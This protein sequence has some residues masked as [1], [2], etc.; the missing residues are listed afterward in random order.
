[1]SSV[2]HRGRFSAWAEAGFGAEL[3]PVEPRGK[4]VRLED[5]PTRVTTAKDLAAW[6]RNGNSVGLRN[7]HFPAIDI[8]VDDD[9]VARDLVLRVA[10]RI[11]G[12]SALRS[13]SGSTRCALLYRL[14]G[15]PFGVAAVRFSRSGEARQEVQVRGTG[16]QLVVDGI[17][18]EGVPYEWPAGEPSAEELAPITQEKRDRFLGELRSELG[19]LGYELEGSSATQA[20]AP[21]RAPRL[22]VV[23]RA[24]RYLAKVPGAISGSGGHAQT[25]LAAEHLVLGFELDQEVALSVLLNDYNPRCS[26]AWTEKD[27]RHKVRE[28]AE[29]GRA[30]RP[31][32]HLEERPAAGAAAPAHPTDRPAPAEPKKQ[33][34]APP[35]IFDLA[36][37]S[38]ATH[39]AIEA[40][41]LDHG[42]Q[43]IPSGWPRLDKAL[44]GGFAVPSLNI[45]GAAPK[46]GK[47]TWAQHV[48]VHHLGQGGAV[49]YVDLENGRRRF[50]RQLICRK[51]ELGS[52][53]V[54]RALENE[55]AG[56]FTTKAEAARWNDAKAWV[57]QRLPLLF[58]SFKPPADWHAC[59]T[60]VRAAAGAR[61]LLVVVDS[62]QKLPGDLAE[63]RSVVDG[64]VR[65]FEQ[66]R[67]ELDAVFLVIS[68]IKRG[69]EGYK[70]GEDAFKESGG[71][72][73]AADLAMT[74]DR[75]RA[76][77][78]E[79]SVSTLRIELARDCDEDP[80]GDVASYVPVRPHYG[81]QE[82]DPEPRKERKSRGRKA[83][84]R[85][86]AET[87]LEQLLQ[88]GPVAV[89]ELEA[90]AS[91]EGI[92]RAT[93]NRAKDSIGAKSCT[94][95]LHSAWRLP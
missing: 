51:A 79:E 4:A 31:G 60:A 85:G 48:A 3:V 57:G 67:H 42:V 27:L 87:L 47:S 30:V 71:I 70:A 17:H 12:A 5:W 52:S 58:A 56:V 9:P 75:P 55:R 15:D 83:T 88:D 73:Y 28:A 11:L 62:L 76:D 33:D 44:G 13:R 81:L 49:L 95:N 69:R 25:L 6:D 93:L 24:R 23:E 1:M 10:E 72:E 86:K 40:H 74:M 61:K 18:P 89:G 29:K 41:T 7:R 54:T 46:S 35:P 59:L 32:Q 45:I 91:A 77:E 16:M 84:A 92:S 19:A 14:E 78:G 36:P 63:R 80:R 20:P 8:D 39:L 66:L 68:E 43:R 94:M 38:I 50:L 82:A 37:L 53:A 26:E 34:A 2:A 90:R 64:W 21:L 65:L 22:D